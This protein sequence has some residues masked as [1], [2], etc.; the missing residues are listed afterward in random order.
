MTNRITVYP[1]PPAAGDWVTICHEWDPAE[2]G[3][4][5]DL[6][7]TFEP[8]GGAAYPVVCPTIG[9]LACVTVMVPSG[10]YALTAKASLGDADTLTRTVIQ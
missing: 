6:D 7:V 1:D 4:A 5:L 2:P 9:G 3:D 8:A 10:T